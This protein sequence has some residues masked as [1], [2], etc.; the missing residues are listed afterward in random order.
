MQRFGSKLR[1][2]RTHHRMTLTELAH[3]L[4]RSAHGYIS[5]IESGKKIPPAEFILSVARL[6]NVTTDVLMK[7]ELDVDIGSEMEE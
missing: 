7:D 4:G 5:E 2:L 3:A 6:F 1:A